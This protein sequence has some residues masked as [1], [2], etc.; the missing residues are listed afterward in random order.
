[1]YVEWGCQNFLK[2]LD[3]FG[4]IY[5]Q[6]RNSVVVEEF[7]QFFIDQRVD[8]FSFVVAYECGTQAIRQWNAVYIG[9]QTV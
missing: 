8:V 9:N 2:F 1:M 6:I 5:T 3:I 7:P 4:Y